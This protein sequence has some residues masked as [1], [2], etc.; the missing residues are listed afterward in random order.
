MMK[1]SLMLDRSLGLALALSAGLALSAVGADLEDAES[2]LSQSRENSDPWAFEIVPYLWL[3]G[4]DGTIGVPDVTSRVS[5]APRESSQSTEPFTSHLSAAAMLTGRVRYRDFGLMLDGAWVQVKTEGQS[6]L[7][8]YSST[9]MKSDIAYGTAALSYRL[10]TFAKLQTDVFAGARVWYISNELTFEPGS[11]QS[12]SSEASRTWA[13]P[14]LGASLR[15]ELTRHWFGS[16]LGDVGGFGVGSDIS[17]SVFGGV[18][19]RFTDWFSATLGYRY[20]HVDYDKEDFLMNVNVPGF[21]LGLGF[22]F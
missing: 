14:I 5:A 18:G 3:A 21:L 10:P 7:P 20:M 15:Y 9:E 2:S 16:V 22:R 11:A 4:Y 8:L 17:W 12:F 19:Y 6:D 13:D 1:N